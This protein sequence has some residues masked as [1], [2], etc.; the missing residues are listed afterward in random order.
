[1]SRFRRGQETHDRVEQELMRERAAALRR[2]GG[3]LA[4]LLDDLH[5]RRARMRELAGDAAD[6]ERTAYDAVRAEARR[7][8]RYLEVQR[9]SVGLR[10]HG[11]L[12]EIYPIPRSF[13]G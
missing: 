1:V 10:S 12:D 3:R 4:G 2:T 6:H 11:R 9:E 5:R 13:D 8:R 7:L